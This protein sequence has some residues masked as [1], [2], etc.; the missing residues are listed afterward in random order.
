[1]QQDYVR[2]IQKRLQA[3]ISGD[4]DG[5]QWL[6]DELK[7]DLFWIRSHR[8]HFIVSKLGGL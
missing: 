5:P 1:V 8:A 4:H 6:L 3:E 2:A 7:R